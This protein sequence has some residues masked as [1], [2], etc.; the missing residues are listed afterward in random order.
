MDNVERLI[1][2]I[3]YILGW[4]LSAGQQDVALRRGA[5]GESPEAIAQWLEKLETACIRVNDPEAPI[6]DPPTRPEDD[7][8]RTFNASRR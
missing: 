8:P 4:K 5:A 1:L 2:D 3:E 6:E 7:D